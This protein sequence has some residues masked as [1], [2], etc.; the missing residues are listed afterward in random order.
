MKKRIALVLTL[1][2]FTVVLNSPAQTVA[3]SSEIKDG[4][5]A[6]WNVEMATNFTMWYTGGGYCAIENESV[7]AFGISSVEEDEV[8]GTLSIGNVTVET[9]DTAVALDL[10]LGVWPTWL[11]GL[12]VE[13]GQNSIESLNESGYA[14]A[15]RVPGNPMNGTMTSRYENIT[16]GQTT[17]EC[18]V[19]DYEQDPPGTQVTH[20]A[21]S[22]STG[23]L[24]EADTTV[25]FGSTYLLVISLLEVGYPTP[26]DFTVDLTGMII[27]SG[28]FGGAFLAVIVI[29]YVKL[30][31]WN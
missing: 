2:I 3:Y 8:I 9:N 1:I 27:F 20:V 13:V 28:V 15:E 26:V 24:V 11:T 5:I 25:T 4:T 14:V 16:V 10:T 18:I 31:R 29:A 17:Q 19:F 23:V 7:M 30:S 6:V 22:L 12:F 21:Y